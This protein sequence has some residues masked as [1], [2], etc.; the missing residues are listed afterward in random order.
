ME[1]VNIT[2]AGE[3]VQTSN[4]SPQDRQLVASNYINSAFGAVNDYLELYIYSE[5]GDL[6]DRDYDASDYYPQ[7]INNLKN[8]TYS[9]LVLDPEKDLKNRGYNRGILNIQ[10]NFYKRLFNSS[11]T[12]LYWIK[13]ISTSRTEIKLASQDISDSSINTGFTQ[14]TSYKATKNYFPLFYLNFGNNQTVCATNVAYVEDESGSYLVIKLYEPLSDNF[15]LKTQLW[16]VDKIAES[17]SYDVNIQVTANTTQQFNT[18]RGPNYNVVLNVK[19]GQTTPYYNYNNLIASPVTSSFQK[20]MSFY[21]DKALA[22]NVDYSDFNNFIHFSSATERVNNFVYKLELIESAKANIA[23]QQSIIGGTQNQTIAASTSTSEQQIINSIISNFDIYEYFLYF[24]SSSW[25]WPK[26][27][28]TQPYQLYS[29]TSSQALN[30]LGSENT[31]P[32]ATTQSL[33]FSASYFDSTNKD[34]LHNSIPQYLL[35]DSANQPYL[36]FLDMIGQHFDNVWIYYKDVSNRYNATNNPNTGIS[37]DLVSDA[38][39]GLGFQLYTNSNISDNLY[40]SLFGINTSGTLLPP[41]GSEMI[42]KYVTSSLTTLPSETIQDELY[43]RLYHNLPYLL[44]TRGSLRGVKALISTF[45][46]PEDILTV[47]EFGGNQVDSL[48]GLLDLNTSNYKISTT[49]TNLEISSSLLSPYTTIQY[50]KDTSRLNT[51]NVE[52]GFS[53]SNTINNNITASLGLFSLDQLVGS[54]ALQYSASYEPLVSASNS[55]FATYTNRNSVWEYIR[56][57]KFYNN[58]IFK[59]IKDF[60]PA[61]ANVSTG[62][63]IKSH[64]FERNKYPRHE[65]QLTFNDYSQSIDM[66]EVSADNGGALSGSTAWSDYVITPLGLASY[67]SSNNIEKYTGELNGSEIIVTD[68]QALEQGE[69]SNTLTGSY[70]SLVNLGATYQNIDKSVRSEVLLDLD[71]NSNQNTPVNYGIVTYSISQSQVDNFSTY[72]NASNPYAQVQDYNY[73]LKRSLLPRYIGSETVSTTYNTYT[74]GDKSYGKTAAIDKGK[75]QYAYLVD[76]Y[77]ASRYMPKRSNAQIK[78]LID[79]NENVLNLTKANQNIFEVQNVYKSGQTT[80]ISLFEYD[81]LNPYSQQ[82]ANNPTVQIYEG[83]FRYLP[84]LHNLSGSSDPQIFDIDNPIKIEIVEGSG[85]NPGDDALQPSNYSLSWWSVEDETEAGSPGT[86]NYSIYVSASYEAGASV[87]Y[88]IQI[89]ANINLPAYLNIC[90]VDATSVTINISSGN[91][92]G[93]VLATSF[94]DWNNTGNDDGGSG[95]GGTHWPPNIG[96]GCGLAIASVIS[97]GGGGTR[98]GRGGNSSTIRTYYVTEISS[99]QSCLYFL[100]QSNEIVFNTTM[101]YYYDQPLTFRSTSDPAWSGSGLDPVILPFTLN[102]GDKISLYNSSSL[103]WDELFEYTIR[104]VRISGSQTNVTSSVILAKMD[105]SV[106]LAL[107]STVTAEAITGADRKTCRYIVWKHVP[108]ETNVMLRFN[109]KSS[110]IVENG[111]LFP[112]Y[113]E[114]VVRDNSGNVIKSLKQ[115]NLI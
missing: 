72:T 12:S 13:E 45:G 38:L 107:F 44:K 79:N 23:K 90:N 24:E 28:T 32:T 111:L 34:L 43:K 30:F 7:I 97:T 96:T 83:G 75:Y 15:Q 21:Q 69:Y 17:V 103:G 99:S 77:N 35:D 3:G 52:V 6:L 16:I 27:T 110:T 102:T 4:L 54:P 59:T 66:L 95:D 8:N 63:I 100:S 20:L 48:D 2:Y 36:T 14:Y 98:P 31:I 9:S 11:D 26:S 60:V 57:L 29:T 78:Y 92:T 80:D 105:T 104:S 50:F 5:T 22:I 58:S 55:Y 113:I 37:L 19:N 64:M 87:P 86:S 106:N 51:A 40:Y 65:P 88:N 94:T 109:P 93:T 33:L 85:A 1:L 39:K 49:T 114:P 84:I 73:N 74:N 46:I 112:Q 108:D 82:L 115:Q 18:L 81:E 25:A 89:T 71:Y 101:S 70:G 61:R 53:P 62:I 91:K 68:G 56:L 42:T 47:R 67:S 41:T 10:Y 76:I